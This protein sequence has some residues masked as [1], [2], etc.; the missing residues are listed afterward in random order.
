MQ[1]SQGLSLVGMCK[2]KEWSGVIWQAES[3]HLEKALS[4]VVKR[5]GQRG[6]IKEGLIQASFSC[7]IEQVCNEGQ[8]RNPDMEKV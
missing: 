6:G 4:E 8:V 5:I 2:D 7:L 3:W 1:K